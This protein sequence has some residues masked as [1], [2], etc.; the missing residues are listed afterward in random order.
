MN[1]I[2]RGD[3]RETGQGKRESKKREWKKEMA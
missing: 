2:V 1:L 3:G